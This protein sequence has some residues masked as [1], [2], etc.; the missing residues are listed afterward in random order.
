MTSLRGSDPPEPAGWQEAAGYRTLLARSGHTLA[1]LGDAL[2]AAEAELD[3]L[4][5]HLLE[6]W[7]TLLPEG[8]S[9]LARW[10]EQSGAL[11][12]LASHR[13]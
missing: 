11:L 13:R 1:E 5:G 3:F 9:S 6:R 4:A 10:T 2:E 8:V 7:L 12:T